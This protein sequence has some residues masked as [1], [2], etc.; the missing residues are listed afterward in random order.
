MHYHLSKTFKIK[1]RYEETIYEVKNMRK[2]VA[3]SFPHEITSIQ[4]KNPKQVFFIELNSLQMYDK[5]L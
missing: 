5:K 3:A 2:D 4:D 1:Y